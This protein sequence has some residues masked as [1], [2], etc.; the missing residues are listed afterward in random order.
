[1]GKVGFWALGVGERRYLPFMLGSVVGVMMA[2]AAQTVQAKTARRAID[3]AILAS[4]PPEPGEYTTD[5][6]EGALSSLM[7]FLC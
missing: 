1:M 7:W 5:S 6:W 4:Y 2:A 3:D